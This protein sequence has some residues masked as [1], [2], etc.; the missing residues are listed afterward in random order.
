MTRLSQF[1]KMAVSVKTELEKECTAMP[2]CRSGSESKVQHLRQGDSVIW[3]KSDADVPDGAVGSIIEYEHGS[4]AMVQW[5]G[6]TFSIKVGELRKAED[7]AGGGVE[8]ESD[9]AFKVQMLEA[10][11]QAHRDDDAESVMSDASFVDFGDITETYLSPDTSLGFDEVKKPKVRR[12][13]RG[14]GR[15]QSLDDSSYR[16]PAMTELEIGQV[17]QRRR[18]GDG[19]GEGGVGTVVGFKDKKRL[20]VQ[21]EDGIS[22]VKAKELRHVEAKGEGQVVGAGDG[23]QNGM[24]TGKAPEQEQLAGIEAQLK[25]ALLAA[26]AAG[27][28]EARDECAAKEQKLEDLEG[29]VAGLSAECAA[30]EEKIKASSAAIVEMEAQR[31]SWKAQ[32]EGAAEAAEMCQEK[33]RNDIAVLKDQVQVLQAELGGIGRQEQ[34]KIGKDTNAGSRR[35]VLADIFGSFKKPTLL[36]PDIVLVG[37]AIAETEAVASPTAKAGARCGSLL[38]G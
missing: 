11:A 13:K 22:S 17:V 9:A 37:N 34:H 1:E 16:A 8:V 24:G 4:R 15:S 25:V 7:A 5:P 18:K 27:M 30:K 6:G 23:M 33:L 28:K 26:E 35:S 2:D 12:R 31:R 32:L 14:H 21:W 10:E 20:L 38:V 3:I 19:A 36:E 29:R